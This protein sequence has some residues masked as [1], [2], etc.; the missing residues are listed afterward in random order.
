M[1]ELRPGRLGEIERLHTSERLTPTL[2]GLRAQA[3]VDPLLGHPFE[4]TVVV[5]Q[6]HL[7]NG[8]SSAVAWSVD[9][10]EPEREDHGTDRR[11]GSEDPSQYPRALVVPGCTTHKDPCLIETTQDRERPEQEREQPD[12]RNE[13][14][15][16][17]AAR[18]IV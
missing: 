11:G 14:A 3:A 5:E 17:N 1:G 15:E 18:E 16:G 9:D 8:R 10:Q 12:E 7:L 2:S 4:L 13:N 6:A